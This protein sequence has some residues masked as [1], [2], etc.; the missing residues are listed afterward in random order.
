MGDGWCRPECN[1]PEYD[2]YNENNDLD[3][4]Y[5][6]PNPCFLNAL[7]KDSSNPD[8]CKSACDNEKGCT[9]FAISDSSFFYPNRA[10]NSKFIEKKINCFQTLSLSQ[11]RR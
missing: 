1:I 2:E 6:P 10:K 11:N 7:T 5:V 4:Y 9:G 3:E 8:E